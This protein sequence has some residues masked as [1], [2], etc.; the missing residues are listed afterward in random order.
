MDTSPYI[1]AAWQEIGRVALEGTAEAVSHQRCAT[2]GGPLH[3]IFT[4]G[5]HTSLN[6]R[7][8]SCHTGT[9]LDGE[10][11]PP[12]WVESFGFQLTTTV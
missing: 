11:D 9:C 3:I 4:P 10:F 6:I 2:C 5:K 8:T 12:P 1:K 7:C